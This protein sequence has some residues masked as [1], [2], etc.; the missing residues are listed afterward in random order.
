MREGIGNTR[1]CTTA[2]LPSIAAVGITEHRI[3]LVDQLEALLSNGI[4]AVQIR[5][6]TAGLT[7]KGSFQLLIR[8][9]GIDPQLRPVIR[10][11][12]RCHRPKVQSHDGSGLDR[13]HPDDWA[14]P[15]GRHPN[16]RQTTH[17]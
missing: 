15:R 5:M 10:I 3:G 8:A 12:G 13:V 14:G 9:V 1:T 11:S 4:I 7:A 6:P 17:P 16:H 2:P